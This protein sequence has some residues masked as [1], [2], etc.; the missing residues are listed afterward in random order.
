MGERLKPAVLKTM[1][2]SFLSTQTIENTGQPRF[3]FALFCL[4]LGP[5]VA[6]V[7]PQSEIS[8]FSP[9]AFRIRGG[10]KC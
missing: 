1:S 2:S 5:N 3:Q 6:E 8:G 9:A 4:V 7:L 10:G